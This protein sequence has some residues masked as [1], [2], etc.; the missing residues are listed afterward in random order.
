MAM[1]SISESILQ[2]KCPK[3]DQKI[4]RVENTIDIV[5]KLNISVQENI[6]SMRE[7]RG[8]LTGKSGE[9]KKWKS[10]ELKFIDDNLELLKNISGQIDSITCKLMSTNKQLKRKFFAVDADEQEERRKER[11]KKENAEIIKVLFSG[12]EAHCP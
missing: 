7:H 5:E 2:K 8:M 6:N 9:M 4:V 3:Q 12:S 1:P 11:R 10:N